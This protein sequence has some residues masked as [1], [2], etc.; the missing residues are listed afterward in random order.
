MRLRPTLSAAA[1]AVRNA[2][3]RMGRALAALRWQQLNQLA[4]LL[5]SV[6]IG[7]GIGCL[8]S[9]GAGLA[10]TGACFVLDS[11]LTKITFRRRR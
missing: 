7:I 10:A 9:P 4:G 3:L 5:G 1:R 11:W 2:A 8:V 6:L